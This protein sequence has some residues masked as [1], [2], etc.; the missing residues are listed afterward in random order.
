MGHAFHREL[1]G[2]HQ[3]QL[4]LPAVSGV[5]HR[6]TLKAMSGPAIEEL[7]E[8]PAPHIQHLGILAAEFREMRRLDR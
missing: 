1:L 8:E 4:R 5:A 7:V 2:Q 6:V 3:G